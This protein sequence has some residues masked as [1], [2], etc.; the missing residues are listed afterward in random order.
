M[1]TAKVTLFCPLIGP[2]NCRNSLTGSSRP[3][4]RAAHAPRQVIAHGYFCAISFGRTPRGGRVSA[5]NQWLCGLRK[6]AQRRRVPQAA[7]GFN[8]TARSPCFSKRR[9][10]DLFSDPKY[11]RRSHPH[12]PG[13][14]VGVICSS[15]RHSDA[16]PR[17]LLPADLVPFSSRIQRC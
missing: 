15:S 5:A 11:R 3:T 6:F 16:R 8:S 1:N 17:D 4:D 13:A 14:V 12:H 2:G 10:A 9:S 7:G